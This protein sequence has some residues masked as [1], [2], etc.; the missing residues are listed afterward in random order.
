M[1]LQTMV[2]EHV[3]V[4]RSAFVSGLVLAARL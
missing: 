2:A 4:A 1:N 3:P